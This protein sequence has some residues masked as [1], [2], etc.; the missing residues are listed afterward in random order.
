[1]DVYGFIWIYMNVYVGFSGFIYIYIYIC[2][3]HDLY[4]FIL[5][6]GVVNGVT[7]GL[8]KPFI[9]LDQPINQHT[10]HAGETCDIQLYDQQIA[11]LMGRML[12][13]YC[14]GIPR[15]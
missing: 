7:M 5:I 2:V 14:S 10:Y 1:M 4:G 9:I 8:S 12:I 3:F 11:V 15:W 13:K 6:Y